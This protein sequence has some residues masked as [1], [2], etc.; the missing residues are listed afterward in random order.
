[1]REQ[2][3][4]GCPKMYSTTTKANL[5]SS[6]MHR[7]RSMIDGLRRE[8]ATNLVHCISRNVSG[9]RHSVVARPSR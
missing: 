3:R 2:P 7:K 1:M 4:A 6:D 8:D 9:A 5:F